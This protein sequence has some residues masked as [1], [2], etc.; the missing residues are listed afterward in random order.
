[1]N[2]LD[3]S[4][5]DLARLDKRNKTS[6]SMGSAGKLRKARL[7]KA[8]KKADSKKILSKPLKKRIG[9]LAPSLAASSVLAR[10][11]ANISALAK[12]S[13]GISKKPTKKLVSASAKARIK[14][15]EMSKKTANSWRTEKKSR[16]V[17]TVKP[18]KTG[19]LNRAT[20]QAEPVNHNINIKGEA[21]PAP[22]FVA[23]L[24]PEASSEDVKT[25]FKQFGEIEACTLMYD[26]DG[27]PTGN[28]EIVYK[29]KASAL[30]AIRKL[31]NVIADGRV[32]IVQPKG[33]IFSNSS[34]QPS[35]SQDKPSHQTT[36]NQKPDYDRDHRDRRDSRSYRDYDYSK[37][38]DSH[39]YRSYRSHNNKNSMDI[40]MR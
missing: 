14:Q 24:D 28:A 38:E 10:V 15:L 39:R 32:L 2:P 16:G 22:I 3:Q 37:R 30:E 7:A 23:N 5:S 27:K 9:T 40:D 19:N 31:N 4:L 20:T 26:S 11:G 12:P 35:N 33:F 18:V 17:K 1:M 13:A 29:L 21:G 25:C 36:R 34:T 6:K 8:S